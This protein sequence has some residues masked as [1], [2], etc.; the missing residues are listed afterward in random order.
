VTA[1]AALADIACVMVFA[2]TGRSSHGEKD[3][4]LGVLATAWPFLVGLAIGWT[5]VVLWSARRAAGAGTAR[6]P[7]DLMGWAHLPWVRPFPA[8]A[9]IATATWGFGLLLR[10]ATDRG[11]TG[12]FPLV[13]LAFLTATLVGWRF[14]VSLVSRRG[15]RRSSEPTP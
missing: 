9:V 5:A 13:A 11:V 12:A 14:L 15:T 3:T 4:A 8:G 2:A 10:M 1:V 7:R 6:E